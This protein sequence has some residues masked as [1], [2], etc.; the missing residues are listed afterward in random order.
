MPIRRPTVRAINKHACSYVHNHTVT[1][2][3]TCTHTRTHTHTHTQYV[4]TH[5]YHTR[6]YAKL[7]KN[8]R[9]GTGR[10]L[11]W[12]SSKTGVFIQKHVK[13]CY[14]TATVTSTDRTDICTG[15]QGR[16]WSSVLTRFRSILI[17]NKF[18]LPRGGRKG[19]DGWSYSM[20]SQNKFWLP[21]GGRRSVEGLQALQLTHSTSTSD[22]VLEMSE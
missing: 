19:V 4:Y 3:N 12:I 8:R 14:N 6:Y 7:K 16:K 2:T 21:W 18:L 5:T 17:Q 1:H 15:G 10:L 9:E 20:G 11:S 13:N 22:Y